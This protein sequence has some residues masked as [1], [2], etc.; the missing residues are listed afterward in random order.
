MAHASQ[1]HL[2]PLAVGG[3]RLHACEHCGLAAARVDALLHRRTKKQPVARP[4][5]VG[6]QQIARLVQ[7]E[8]RARADAERQ[9]VEE[10]DG[11]L[12]ARPTGA[13]SVD[14]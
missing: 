13:Q 10:E 8:A 6:H 7:N 5:L 2:Q 4:A 11:Q 3:A 1:D 12:G 9:A 14:V